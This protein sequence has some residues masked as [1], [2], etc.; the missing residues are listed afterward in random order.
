MVKVVTFGEFKRPLEKAEICFL[1]ATC[2]MPPTITCD[3]ERLKFRPIGPVAASDLLNT[4][5]CAIYP[6]IEPGSPLIWDERYASSCR[7]EEFRYLLLDKK[8]LLVRTFGEY[9]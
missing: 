1:Q 6:L 2:I 9:V 5:G 3:L 4:V 7:Y 8:T